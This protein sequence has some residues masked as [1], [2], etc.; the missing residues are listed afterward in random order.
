MNVADFYYDLPDEL[1]AQFPP[2][3]RTDSR[4]LKLP[5]EGDIVDA[6]F[7]DIIDEFRKGDL[8]VLNDTKVVPARIHG[9][10]DTGGKLEIMLERVTGEG[11]FLAQ[12]KASKAPRVGQKIFANKDDSVTL[13]VIGRQGSFF[14]IKC[15]LDKSLFSWFEKVGHIPL[16]PYIE[17]EDGPRDADRYQ[18]VFA[19]AKGAVA[20]PTAGLHYDDRLL[21]RIRA[22]GV[23]IETVTLHVG[24]G[25]YQPVRAERISEHEMHSEHIEVRLAIV[26]SR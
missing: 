15:D 16:P 3:Q 1:I 26:L 18:T 20:A 6:H 4:L 22:K 14:N 2:K 17:R 21:Q 19:E 9:H 11:E 7:A 23:Q 12:L 5:A 13:T 24:A 8:L 25:T 10:K